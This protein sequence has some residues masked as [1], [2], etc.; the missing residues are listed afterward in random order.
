MALALFADIH[1]NLEA[2][3]ACLRHARER[4][5]S[6]FAFLGD[7]VG[8][9]ADPKAVIAVAADHARL[10]AIVVKGNHDASVSGDGGYLND[11]AAR[12]MEWTRTILDAGERRFLEDLPLLVRRDASCF[13]HASANAPE[14]WEYVDGPGSVRRSAD[15]AATRF[16]FSGHVHRPAL[17]FSDARDRMVDFHPR[18]GT[19]IPLRANSRYLVIPGSVGQPRDGNPAA[20]YA[21]I[22]FDRATLVFHRVPYDHEAAALKIRR[23]GLPESLAYRLERGA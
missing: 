12:S 2:L 5:A 16:T 4:D 10:G 18:P 11:S 1:A 7:L 9:G 14:R 17:H 3:E 8:Y 6:S 19:P 21:M 20:A 22:D 23:A 13:V 15:A